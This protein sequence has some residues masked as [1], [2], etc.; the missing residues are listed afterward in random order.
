MLGRALGEFLLFICLQDVAVEAAKGAFLAQACQ[1]VQNSSENTFEEIYN[2]TAG[3]LGGGEEG[4]HSFAAP[5]L[6]LGTAWKGAAE[7]TDSGFSHGTETAMAVQLW[8]ASEGFSSV[9]WTV[10]QLL[11]ERHTE[12]YPDLC[13]GD[14]SSPVAAGMVGTPTELSATEN[15]FRARLPRRWQQPSPRR[16]GKGKQ[17]DA[18]GGK[19]K[20][21]GSE[22]AT[23]KTPAPPTLDTLPTM[24]AP[25]SIQQPRKQGTE[26]AQTPEKAH[27]DALL[28]VLS[29]SSTTLPPEA[30]QMIAALQESNSQST[31]KAMHKAVAEQ[32]KARQTLAKVQAQRASY[33]QAWHT[34]TGQLATLLEQ[35][36]QEQSQVL[37]GLDKSEVLW[38]QADQQATQLLARLAGADKEPP[39]SE[40][41]MEDN[42]DMVVTAV[43]LESKLQKATE[44]SQQSAKQMIG[45][46]ADM[47]NRMQEHM[48]KNGRDGS[49]TPR[50]KS[51]GE[52]TEAAEDSTKNAAKSAGAKGEVS[53]ED[54]FGCEVHTT[55]QD[56]R[57]EVGGLTAPTYY[58]IELHQA[59]VISGLCCAD[60]VDYRQT[61]EPPANRTFLGPVARMWD[62]D[63]VD[64][65]A[66]LFRLPNGGCRCSMLDG[67][68]QALDEPGHEESCEVTQPFARATAYQWAT[69]CPASS[70][71]SKAAP[72]KPTLITQMMAQQ[73]H[74]VPAEL[75]VRRDKGLPEIV[76]VLQIGSPRAHGRIPYD[77]FEPEQG[78]R[79]RQA[80]I[81]WTVE[82]LV[83]DAAH[84]VAYTVRCIQF[85]TV[86]IPR[87]FRPNLV[88]TPARAGREKI[89]IP[90]D[91]R[92][93]GGG[94]PTVLSGHGMAIAEV[95]HQVID[96]TGVRL[97][98]LTDRLARRRL[99]V[100][101]SRQR[102]VD[103]IVAPLVQYEWLLLSEVG[104][105]MP[106]Q[107]GASE[108]GHDPSEA[109]PTSWPVARLPPA[110]LLFT[111]E[112]SEASIA[113]AGAVQIYPAVFREGD[114]FTSPTSDFKWA[115]VTRD[116][117]GYFTVFDAQ[118]HVSLGCGSTGA[119]RGIKTGE[120][121]PGQNLFEAL[122]EVEALS[123]G[124]LGPSH[125][126]PPENLEAIQHM[127]VFTFPASIRFSRHDGPRFFGSSWLH[128]GTT[129]STTWMQAL[130]VPT[131]APA[132]RLILFRGANSASADLSPPYHLLDEIMAHL[133][134]QISGDHPLAH[135]SGVVLS[136]SLPPQLGYL[137]EVPLVIMEPTAA[138]PYLWDA[139]P[140]GGGLQLLH[141]ASDAPCSEI[142]ST[143]WRDV[144]W[145]LAINGVPEEYCNRPIRAGDFLQPFFGSQIQTAVPQGHVLDL[146]PS[147]EAYTWYAP[148]RPNGIPVA[149]VREI[150]VRLGENLRARRHAMG[151]HYH[152]AGTASVHGSFH[153]VVRLHF[154]RPRPPGQ[155]SVTQALAE[156]DYPQGWQEVS[157][158]AVAVPDTAIYAS[159]PRRGNSNTV[160]LPAPRHPE[161]FFV[162][163]ISP[164]MSVLPD[165]PA[166]SGTELYPRRDLRTGD[167]LYFRRER[168]NDPEPASSA[169]GTDGHSLLQTR[170]S[171]KKK[172]IL[173]SA[174]ATPFGR[175]DIPMQLRPNRQSTIIQLASEIPVAA[176]EVCPSG[177][178]KQRHVQMQC[179]VNLDMFEAAFEGFGIAMFDKDWSDVPSLHPD[180][181]HFL[182]TCPRICRDQPIE[183]MQMYV[184]GSF[185]PCQG[186]GAKAGWSICALGLQQ[187]SWG[188]IGIHVANAPCQGSSATLFTP[189]RSCFEAELAATCHAMAVACAVPIPTLIAFDSTSAGDLAQG[190]CTAAEDT[191]LSRATTSLSH[192]LDAVGRRPRYLHISSPEGHPL[193]EAADSAAKAAARM[194]IVSQL[195]G[196]FADAAREDVLEWLWIAAGTN[197]SVPALSPQGVLHDTTQPAQGPCL[198]EL[199]HFDRVQE[200]IE[201]TF[202]AVSY[203]CCSLAAKA[204]KE[205]I[206]QQLKKRKVSIAGLQETRCHGEARQHNADFHILA[207]DADQGQQGCQIWFSKTQPVGWI[208]GHPLRWESNGFSAVC[209]SPR[210]LL[211][212]AKVGCFKVA[213]MCAHAPTAAA[214]A[215]TREAWW[216]QFHRV[217]KM[218]PHTH[219]PIVLVDANARLA[220][221]VST[222]GN[223][224]MLREFMAEQELAHSACVNAAGQELCTWESPNGH[225]VCIDYILCPQ[226]V[227]TGMQ[228]LGVLSNFV[229]LLG[230]DHRPVAVEFR[231]R[232][233]AA[234]TK[235]THRLDVQYLRT[236]SGQKEWAEHMR[237]APT[238]AW[239][240]DVDTHLDVLQTYIKQGLCA[241][242]PKAKAHA[243]QTVTSEQTWQLIKF[244]RQLRRELHAC[245]LAF[246]TECLR[247][248]FQAWRTQNSQDTANEHMRCLHQAFLGLQIR[249]ASKRVVQ[250]AK[251]D[252]AQAT[253]AIFAEARQAGPERLHRLFRSVLK[254]GRKY[255]R[256]SLAP[257]IVQSDGTIAADSQELIG[258]HFAAAER[259]TEIQADMLRTRPA[260]VEQTVLKV[261]RTFS[262]SQVA[263]AFGKLATKKAA[264]YSEIPTEV[265]RSAPIPTA[266]CHTPLLLK[267]QMRS[268][269]PALW[270]GGKA[271]PIEKPSKNLALPTGWRS[272]M[273]VEAG[274]KGLGRAMRAALLEG[275]EKARV[276]GQGGSRPRAP[277]QTAMSQVRGFLKDIR[278]KQRSG[279]VLFVDGQAAFYATIRQYLTGRDGQDP[280]DQLERLS[281]ALFEEEVDRDKFIATALAPGLLEIHGVP[282]EVRRV[283]AAMLDST[284]FGLGDSCDRLYQTQTG[285]PP[286]APLAD[287]TFQYVFATVLDKLSQRLQEAGCRA[288][289]GLRSEIV[290]PAPSWMDD[291]AVPFATEAADKVIPTAARALQ[292]IHDEMRDIGISVNWG[293]GKSELLPSFQ[294][295]GAK[296]EQIK[297]CAEPD[298]R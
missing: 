90:V 163:L 78:R 217:F 188:W 43:E 73:A 221:T 109:P 285:T 2:G 58:D 28:G 181:K 254:T 281:E 259:A 22:A 68:Q 273:L 124:L 136:G 106:M 182:Q 166:G 87:T 32:A 192:L 189:V 50:R 97:R 85:P 35:Q 25:P 212:L 206:Q 65:D 250:S 292:I 56:P 121:L 39:D 165:L 37:E 228:S 203:N 132:L 148:V 200:E 4:H 96:K 152:M 247:D 100:T 236:P 71:S 16:R 40:R 61:P 146:C 137:Q 158:T 293:P 197:A 122:A 263:H 24:P 142:L 176:A 239:E 36:L 276:E 57:E 279:G 63:T 183:A 229:G 11:G 69:Q 154:A 246:K 231:L 248:C 280:L 125:S 172:N 130:S 114:A 173:H 83:Q 194:L 139:R 41:E 98:H 164:D 54:I 17:K 60:Y 55:W 107:R 123:P 167:V 252:A 177:D 47:Q 295:R 140:I 191:T 237:K 59:K 15:G 27:L 232:R 278:Q 7:A 253:R 193:N 72:L 143:S 133:L 84:A 249:A 129:A 118:R 62:N 270:R 48:A 157:R 291:V 81:T 205:S 230:H 110:N 19:G 145:R 117:L 211:V 29:A 159:K 18:K 70:S 179:G 86:P 272:I 251:Q 21:A 134:D 53:T 150:A 233:E 13:S 210:I 10:W 155:S 241:I 14:R 120:H 49:R 227:A 160:L 269:V 174:I 12:Q 149:T 103:F 23:M 88:M 94:I 171:I 286:G 99:E 127:R 186:H 76:D 208:N 244:R 257:A 131:A 102:T 274:A 180:A 264:G 289:I 45:A 175:R 298:S 161:H 91:A 214:P 30:Q 290:A 218:I 168:N 185:F 112:P 255:R 66:V 283:V 215:P 128:E 261:T 234:L 101:D 104:D 80:Q 151:A 126:H 153:G 223:A 222:N 288:L 190:F 245:R 92:E 156:L 242:C 238:I 240:V 216:K 282:L 116:T 260:P 135:G 297:W 169:D 219:L 5:S 199:L 226:S 1:T 26:T 64:K 198:G 224:S 202:T 147:L 20:Y 266:A 9:L 138:T 258:R 52:A 93:F 275:F 265:F 207:S 3:K 284:W 267:M 46:L 277:M 213:V 209:R 144:Q 42:E 262:L 38:T 51:E 89:A 195:P 294:G 287:L 95:I 75:E 82:E 268:Q 201:L 31:T 162:L 6:S 113:K 178:A 225:R 196:S 33:L 256:P 184:D 8:P 44:E 108:D 77:L 235:Q 105:D 79:T 67:D 141:A 111:P 296:Q 271:V 204:Q 74:L 243:R 119:G 170:A 187:G 34:Y 220:A 115:R